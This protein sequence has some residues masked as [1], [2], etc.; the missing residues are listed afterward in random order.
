M[1]MRVDVYDRPHGIPAGRYEC[2]RCGQI[3]KWV[4]ADVHRI[5]V[6]CAACGGTC[7]PVSQKKASNA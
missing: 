4:A 3:I 6:K 7:D 1:V 5:R 2:R